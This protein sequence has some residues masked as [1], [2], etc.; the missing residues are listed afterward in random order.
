MRHWRGND[1]DF[2]TF[3]PFFLHFYAS[4]LVFLSTSLL[5]ESSDQAGAKYENYLRVTIEFD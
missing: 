2:L 3:I 1:F 4:V 5:S